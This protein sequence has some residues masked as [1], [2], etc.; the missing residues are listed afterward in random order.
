MRKGQQVCIAC[1]TFAKVWKNVR[2]IGLSIRD[3]RGPETRGCAS[4]TDQAFQGFTALPPPDATFAP[5]AP[6][7]RPW[8]D[9]LGVSREA[10]VAVVSA[11]YK[12]LAR[13]ASEAEL[14][15]LN[16][17]KEA[18]MAATGGAK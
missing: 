18:A 5:T 2:A 14:Y 6:P 10:P 11:A 1:D 12:A 13:S 15:A 3:M 17:A 9:V 8:W 7:P 4:I 16:A